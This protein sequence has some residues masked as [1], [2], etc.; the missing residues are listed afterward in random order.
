MPIIRLIHALYVLNTH[1]ADLYPVSLTQSSPA[2]VTDADLTR[3]VTFSFHRVQGLAGN[4]VVPLSEFINNK[5]TAK[6]NRQLQGTCVALVVGKICV[7][8]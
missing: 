8:N 4:P 7:V 2:L 3:D 1:W 5:L 6:A